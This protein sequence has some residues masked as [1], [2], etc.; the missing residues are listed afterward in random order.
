MRVYGLLSEFY[1]TLIT[2]SF[3]LR[4]EHKF[5]R[6]SQRHFEILVPFFILEMSNRAKWNKMISSHNVT[7]A[8]ETIVFYRGLTVHSKAQLIT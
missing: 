1:N 6:V 2:S 7:L 4:F 3:A 5:L 8:H